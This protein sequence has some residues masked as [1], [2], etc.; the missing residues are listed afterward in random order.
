MESTTRMRLYYA[1]G[2]CSLSTHIVARESELDVEISKVTFSPEGRTT[3]HGEDYYLVNK[4]GGYVPALRLP[5]D[6]VMAEGGAIIQYLADKA[7]GKHLA[8][9][10][11]TLEHYRFLEWLMFISTELHKGFSPLF[12]ADA[13]ETEKTLAS[14]KLNKRYAYVNEALEG[15]EY[16][17]GTF[18]VADAYLY[19]ILRWSA[20]ANID[21]ATYPNLS[22][23]MKLM[24]SRK[25]VQTALE[26]EGLDP[27]K[28]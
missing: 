17:L 4:K 12:R 9:E 13:P 26:E 10:K 14:D 2:A 8:P 1:P 5:N 18:S 11:G 24:E 15:K 20:R 6:E 22:V 21:L 3:E 19:T 23:F 27:F 28:Q 25:G 16:L 7:E